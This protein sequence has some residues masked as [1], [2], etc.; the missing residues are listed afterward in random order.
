MRFWCPCKQKY[1][2]CVPVCGKNLCKFAKIII[3][4]RTKALMGLFDE[5]KQFKN[6]VRLALLSLTHD[7]G[8]QLFKYFV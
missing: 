6:Y 4:L 3:S 8:Q 2:N 7:K 1:V 5:I